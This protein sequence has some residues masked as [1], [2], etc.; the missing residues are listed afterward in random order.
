MILKAVVMGLAVTFA[1][2]GI[3]GYLLQAPLPPGDIFG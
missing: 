1:L 2:I 3:F